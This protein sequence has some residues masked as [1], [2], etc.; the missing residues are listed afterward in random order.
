M[1]C[2]KILS[3]LTFFTFSKNGLAK[4]HQAI[5]QQKKVAVVTVLEKAVLIRDILGT[6][7]TPQSQ[8]ISSQIP[9]VIVSKRLEMGSQ[10]KAGSVIAQLDDREANARYD[11]SLAEVDMA[12]IRV[13]QKLLSFSRV[14]KTYQKKLASK[15]E[16]DRA[17][18]ELKQ[19]NSE[20]L[21]YQAK[22]KLAKYSLQKHQIIAPFDGVLVTDSPVVGKQLMLGEKVVELLNRSHLR[23]T[24]SF[25][26]EEVRRLKSSTAHLVFEN[27]NYAV[28]SIAS[29]SPKTNIKNGMITV[30]FNLSNRLNAKNFELEDIFS[31]QVLVLKLIENRLSVPSH[32]ISE[33][34]N[35]Q[36][37]LT[38]HEGRVARV[39]LEDLS[40]GLKVIVM[41]NEK[42]KPG[43]KISTIPLGKSSFQK[44]ST[45]KI[46]VENVSVG[47]ISDKSNS[48]EE[49][50]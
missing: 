42:V 1:N 8:I 20:L 35:G 7:Y 4:D 27:F 14:E 31:G 45:Q 49:I 40:V 17:N 43:E 30:E 21:A 33:D 50:L 13:K 11:L 24:A 10:V 41:G 36:Y 2:L 9:G 47:K 44:S 25:T 48:I 38:V 29:I 12:K 6:T 3:L 39:G 22:A 16:Y 28:L 19:A 34:D 26:P 18:L 23:I 46:S 37:V 5:E 15:A 32:A